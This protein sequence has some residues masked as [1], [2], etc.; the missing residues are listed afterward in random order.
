MGKLLPHGVVVAREPAC[1]QYRIEGRYY[2]AQVGPNP[3]GSGELQE[4]PGLGLNIFVL[5]FNIFRFV[6]QIGSVCVSK[7]FVL[8][9]K[10]VR[11]AF[12]ND[13]F[14]V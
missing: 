5:C 14:C 9:F 4:D 11:F 1:T 2:D 3:C 8:C 6:F 13:P 12:E 10:T 7:R